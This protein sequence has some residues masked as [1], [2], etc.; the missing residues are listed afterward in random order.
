[1]STGLF[2]RDA[3][4]GVANL[5]REPFTPGLISLALVLALLLAVALFATR[6]SAKTSALSRLKREITRH[7]GGLEF[8]RN[9]TNV[10]ARINAFGS[11]GCKGRVAAG[12]RDFRETLVPHEEGDE[13]VLRNSVRPSAF[14]NVDD[15]GFST[16]FWRIVP[17]L[18]V[19][20]G[21]FLTFLGLVS[22]LEA[23]SGKGGNTITAGQL[24]ELLTVA[25]AKF[26]MSLTGLLC[27]IIFTIAL[28]MGMSK[29]EGMTHEL[30]AAM[31]E[32]LTFI[33]LESLAVEQLAA[34]R[35]QREHFRSIGLELIAELGRPFRE[36]IPAAISSS[37]SAAMAPLLEQVGRAGSEGVGT[38]IQDLSSRFTDDVGRALTQASDKL[39]QAGD[40]IGQLSERMDQSSS[41]VGSELDLAV[42]RIAQ[43]IDDIRGAM[44]A[45]ASSTSGAF[46]DGA[47]KLL[48]IM[49]HTLEGIRENTS[50][51]A[52]AMSVAAADL[53]Q[54]G[55]A[56]RLQMDT[57]ARS[58]SDA[59]RERIEATGGEIARLTSE[60]SS[61]ATADLLSPLGDIARQMEGVAGQVASASK[62]FR[63]LSEGVQDG[64]NASA[65]AAINFRSASQE[66]VAAAT[67]LRATAERIEQ[68]MRELS[69]STQ[70]VS[71]AIIRSAEATA[72][73]AADALAAAQTVLS[74][75][76]AAI[77]ATLGG[78]S[79]TLERL[80][81]QGDRLDDLDE[82]LGAAFETYTRQVDNAVNGMRTHVRELQE[83]LAPALDTLRAIVDQAEQFM[84]QSRKL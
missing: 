4:L 37:I 41:R 56:F 62:D 28:R 74:G 38:L 10:D 80:K 54:A 22:A 34:V 58:G 42:G 29:L 18:F 26:I 36:E 39:A 47:E 49:N 75:E 66:L 32:R 67:P 72:Q 55:E 35:E 63:M 76:A 59:A 7:R 16:G 6:V 51:G 68:S 33:S 79:V 82:K 12:W 43:S 73:N 81:G 45:T 69:D 78:V 23:I 13:I 60:L 53:Q 1:M 52:R 70:N 31:E 61:R 40:R 84:P 77:D 11:S 9:I 15:L 2:V 27:S 25:S 57:A 71:G 24:N 14:F 3:V 8:S 44:T 46:S 83:Q 20:T 50:E 64:A 17:S 5:L 19:S 21:L 65:Q 30:A 48:A